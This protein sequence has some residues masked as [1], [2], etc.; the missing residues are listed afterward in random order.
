MFRRVRAQ[1]QVMV[2]TY[3]LD[4]L[5]DREVMVGDAP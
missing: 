1:L 3:H 4:T 5:T 2:T